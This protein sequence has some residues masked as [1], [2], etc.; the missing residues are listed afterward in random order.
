MTSDSQRAVPSDAQIAIGQA[1]LAYS[2]SAAITPAETAFWSGAGKLIVDD[3]FAFLVGVIFNQN[4]T[5]ER[6]FRVPGELKARLHHLDPA[7]IWADPE[8]FMQAVERPPALHRFPATIA[9]FVVAS[10]DLVI[11]RYG[12]D[13]G[14]IWNDS[15]SAAELYRRLDEFPGIGQKKASMTVE[16]IEKSPYFAL[17]G[18]EGTDI[19]YDI[20][21]RR[22]FLRSGLSERDD[23]DDMIAIARALN[24]KRP[25]ALDNPAWHIG[26]QWCHR[27]EP[28][29]GACGLTAACPKLLNPDR[30]A[31]VHDG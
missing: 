16:A 30:A 27:R 22:V 19:S 13:A 24:P 10:A 11:R 4:I 6:A 2:A 3:P 15:P 29:C 26:R 9:K 21:L 31:T 23:P 17:S 5:A 12:G 1:L 7:R 25:G 14:R 8:A 28:E 18:L 20:H